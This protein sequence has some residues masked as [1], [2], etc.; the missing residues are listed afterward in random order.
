[1]KTLQDL[2]AAVDELAAI[3]KSTPAISKLF[4][5]RHA[6][7]RDA[8]GM[9]AALKWALDDSEKSLEEFH[10]DVLKRFGAKGKDGE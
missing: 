6:F 2:Q 8:P 1:M 7:D 10:T 9:L 5:P 3:K 4:K